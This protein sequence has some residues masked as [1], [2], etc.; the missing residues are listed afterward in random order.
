MRAWHILRSRLRSILRRN[1]REDELAEEL[2]LH[3]E[4]QTDLWVAQGMD[5][6]AARL[7][8]RRQFGAV[9][10]LKEECRDARGTAFVDHVRRDIHHSARR[11]LR[12]WRF[13]AAAVVILGLGIGANTVMFSVINAA[14]FRRPPVADPERLVE[15]YQNTREGAPGTNSYPAYLD[16]ATATN[17]FAGVAAVSI[18]TA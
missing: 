3:I 12:D 1:S 9:E 18:P 5:R 6:E 17:V 8:A 13:T 11:L 15:V 16:V 2:R 4:R 14:L 7:Q 10:A